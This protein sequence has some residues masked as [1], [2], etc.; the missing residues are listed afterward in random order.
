TAPAAASRV[1][2]MPVPSSSAA[3][4]TAAAVRAP[5]GATIV[6]TSPT[7]KPRA[8]LTCTVVAFGAP[9]ATTEPAGR[10]T[11]PEKSAT[12]LVG[13]TEVT[14]P[15]TAEGAAA[16][17]AAPTGGTAVTVSPARRPTVEASGSVY[18]PSAPVDAPVSSPRKNVPLGPSRSAPT[19]TTT[20]FAQLPPEEAVTVKLGLPA[21]SATC[22]LAGADGSTR[23]MYAAGP[24]FSKKPKTDSAV[25][26]RD[27]AGPKVR[28]KSDQL[29]TRVGFFTGPLR[30]V[31]S[32]ATTLVDAAAIGWGPEG[33]SS[34]YTPGD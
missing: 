20:S 31:P 7:L 34:M 3:V 17:A 12:M 1:S 27:V 6:T 25:K 30:V 14:V 23:T 10:F 22:Q 5:F 16:G 15:V 4:T 28:T 11:V 9:L 2:T 33:T 19:A 8:V 29:V 24:P 26:D 21:A 13:E 18:A 32:T